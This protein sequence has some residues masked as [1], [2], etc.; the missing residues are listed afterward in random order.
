MSPETHEA[1]ENARHMARA[2]AYGPETRSIG[3]DRLQHSIYLFAQ[4]MPSDMTLG[5]LCDELCNA[6]GQAEFVGSIPAERE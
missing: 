2:S 1:I 6:S 5:E 3:F 4:E